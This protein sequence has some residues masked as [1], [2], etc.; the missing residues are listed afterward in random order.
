[1]LSFNHYAYGAV[2]DWMYRYLAGISPDRRH[3]GYRRV[4]LA[5][6]PVGAIDWV[7]ASIDSGY[8]TIRGRWELQRSGD[9]AVA[10]TIPVGVTGHFVPPVQRTSEVTIDGVAVAGSMDLPPGS[11]L[12]VVTNPAVS[13]SE[14]PDVG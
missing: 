6:K 13:L 8:G 5:P 2:V 7:D 3:P 4:L 1:M 10:L 11:H 14:Q 12:V 9:L